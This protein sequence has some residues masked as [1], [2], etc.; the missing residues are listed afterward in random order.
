MN[1]EPFEDE[2][3]KARKILG[4]MTDEARWRLFPIILCEYSPEY[5]ERFL[6]EKARL[7]AKLGAARIARLNH[8]GSTSVPGLLAK[9]TIDLLMEI[10]PSWDVKELTGL[11]EGADY[12]ATAQPQSPAPH[13]TFL[14]GYTPRGFAREVF[15]LHIRFSGDW[16]ELYFRDYLCAHPDVT[17]EYA[18]RKTELARQFE[19]N[20]DAYTAAKG[21]FVQTYTRRA[22]MK[23]TGRYS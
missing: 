12:L 8:I 7:E 15:H 14:K 1:S 16:D 21:E 23:F 22:R 11:L 5:P 18:E 6:R 3:A 10:D 9:P 19:F 13:L 2:S 17:E 20:R 4:E